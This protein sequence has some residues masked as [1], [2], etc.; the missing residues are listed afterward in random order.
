VYQHNGGDLEDDEFEADSFL[1]P[2]AGALVKDQPS[3]DGSEAQWLD[4]LLETLGDDEDEDGQ[5]DESHDDDDEDSLLSPLGSPLASAH[6]L[7]SQPAYYPP[8]IELPYPPAPYP[9]FEP[10]P[11]LVR[12]YSSDVIFD[13]ILESGPFSLDVL[14][15]H[16]SD[17]VEDMS[18]PDA[19]EDVS[20][21]ESD[22]PLT[23]S[24]QSPIALMVDPALVPL[25]ED[26]SNRRRQHGLL[27]P[28]P[29]RV[30]IDAPHSAFYHP[31]EFESEDPLPFAY[32]DDHIAP[33]YNPFY[34]EC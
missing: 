23:P 25:P 14:P 9:P 32:L 4:S 20:D 6:N 8:P 29:P 17:D 10:N 34:Q 19:I 22:S 26:G 28:P 3:T 31:F 24:V 21:D 15:Y 13:P 12:P 16:D 27:P 30:Y 5:A 1:F 2:D 11:S 18:V 33:S 7:L